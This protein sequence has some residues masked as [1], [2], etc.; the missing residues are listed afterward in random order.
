MSERTDAA[1]FAR[2]FE[3]AHDAFVVTDVDGA[4]AV[5]SPTA[6]RLYGY[7]AAEAVG[8]PLD[9]LCFPEERSGLAALAP[10]TGAQGGPREV[11]LRQRH[12]S[13]RELRVSLRIAP[14]DVPGRPPGLLL[15]AADVSPWRQAED[16]HAASRAALEASRAELG[17]VTGRLV[18][19]EEGAR[20]RISQELHDD[21][22]QRLAA[23]ALELRVMRRK[24]PEADPQRLELEAV[25][26]S[27]AEAAEDLRSLSHHLHP[28]ILERRGLAEALRDHCEE[29]GRRSSLPMRLSLSDTE[30]PLPPQMA[31]GLYRIAQEALANAVRHAGARAIHVTLTANAAAVHLTVADDGA[32]FE[33]GPS[34]H[35]GGLGLSGIEER[36]R[37]LGGLCRIT[38]APGAGTEVHVLVPLPSAEPDGPELPVDGA[39][40]QIGP[41]QLLEEI[42]TG[43]MATVYLAQEPEPLS[44]KVAL[45]LHRGPLPGRRET[46]R[47]KAEQQALARLH[48]PAI[49]Q[50]YEARTTEDGDLYIIMEY[51][52]G[53]PVTAY[54]DR[55]GLDLG[56]R[57]RIFAAICDGVQHAHQNGVLH[58]DL[59]PSNLLVMEQEGE[60]LPKIID[61]G[62]AK[63]LDHP[64]AE[65][66]VSSTERL[67]GTPAYLA[68][69]ALAGGETDA[70]SDVYALGVVLYE[71]LTGTVPTEATPPSRRLSAMDA[72]AAAEVARCRGLDRASR[73]RRRLAGDLDRI[74]LKALALDPAER[75]PTVEALRSEVG[76]ALRGEP[77]EAGPAGALHQLSRMVRR[78]RKLVAAAALVFLA[79]AAGLAA[80]G[81]QARRARQEAVRADAA[82]RFLEELFQASDPRQARGQVPDTRELLERGTRRLGKDL[83][84]QPLLRAQLLD[85]LGGIHTELGLF[86]E[87]RPLLREAL[88]IRQRLLGSETPEAAATLV[89]LGALA[90]LSGKGDAVPLFQRALAIREARLGSADPAVAD[91]LNN[92]GAALAAKGR[93]DEAETTLR[94]SLALHEELWGNGDPRVAKILH[95]LGGIAYYRGRTADAE[96]LLQRALTIREAVL[97]KDDPDLAGSLE[98][99]AL[100]RQNQGRLAEAVELLERQV[101]IAERVY[102]PEH[103]DFARTLLN[104]GLVR[105][106]LGEDAAVQRLFERALGIQEK[107]LAPS[108]P[109]L[110]RTLASLADLHCVHRRWATAEPFLRRLMKLKA[111][112]A[113]Y[114]DW[115]KTLANWTR[116]LRATGREAEAA[117]VEASRR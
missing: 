76:R 75:Y 93:F 73:L 53:M 39:P 72:A 101:Q 5:W 97:A 21:L 63:G 19:A 12:K 18:A 102:G 85:T 109:V 84:G 55:Y 25:G 41:Y 70:R 59:K 22:C 40:R 10:L 96:K 3:H 45:K 34:R 65:S 28:A 48:H 31:L 91:V 71:L 116:F 6:E 98:A 114:S 77:V 83:Q 64:L 32:G 89:R 17:R 81:L 67:S 13:G 2:V 27:L 8:R 42:G 69:E 79:L 105:Q 43:S 74:A 38:S 15:C 115:D 106:D 57:L 11:L 80:T 26:G 110:V 111:G 61:F 99:M 100:V 9:L 20:R 24:L 52:P 56:R 29:V 117:R 50:V 58:R 49:A 86:D 44:R 46:L 4:I 36:A 51:V 112:G 35:T 60:T 87:A 107:T 90:H 7:T 47:F 30:A 78:H 108:H 82:A 104:L 94:R 68:P 62:A 1:F 88:A 66:T 37:L 92:L 23:M 113:V 14:L 33:T 54:C 16:E 95:N 103:P